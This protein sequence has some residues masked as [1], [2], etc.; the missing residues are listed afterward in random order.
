MYC[1]RCGAEVSPE[2]NYCHKC[3][4]EIGAAL[5]KQSA[6]LTE[7]LIWAIVGITVAGIGVIIGLMAVMKEVAG[8]SP[9]VITLVTLLCLFM[10]FIADAVFIWM[11]LKNSR[12][13]TPAGAEKNKFAKPFARENVLEMPAR[14][15]LSEAMPVPSVVENTTRNLEPVLR[16]SK[17][18]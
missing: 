3:G 2:L 1:Q 18:K 15:E 17:H 6:T 7:S 16:E 13:A 14:A 11:L 5:I 9:E 12:V 10:V 4:N 8:L